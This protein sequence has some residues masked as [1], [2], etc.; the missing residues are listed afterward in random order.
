MLGY[1]GIPDHGNY[2]GPAEG[3]QFNG[4]VLDNHQSLENPLT[5]PEQGN[6]GGDRGHTVHELTIDP[7]LLDS[8]PMA[9]LNNLL[10]TIQSQSGL[11]APAVAGP[12]N[13]NLPIFSST[14]H[15]DNTPGSQYSHYSPPHLGQPLP[16]AN[17][18][19]YYP[20]AALPQ[21]PYNP[22]FM[23]NY[24]QGEGPLPSLPYPLV[25][26]PWNN[27]G[28]YSSRPRR[29]SRSSTLI[30]VE[31]NVYHSNAPPSQIGTMDNMSEEPQLQASDSY[32]PVHD[33]QSFVSHSLPT[34]GT[35]ASD[36]QI[37]YM[38]GEPYP[39]NASAGSSMPQR[40]RRTPSS[41]SSS[42]HED[43]NP[44]PTKKRGPKR[45]RGTHEPDFI[46]VRKKDRESCK[47]IC[48]T[49]FQCQYD[50]SLDNRQAISG[51]ALF[52]RADAIVKEKGKKLVGSNG[53]K[54]PKEEKEKFACRWTGCS[55]R[56]AEDAFARHFVH[57]HSPIKTLCLRCGQDLARVDLEKRHRETCCANNV[58]KRPKM[59]V[60]AWSKFE[61]VG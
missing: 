4:F 14:A 3:Q 18:A 54:V 23:Y 29:L 1:S 17:L 57:H 34:T 46:D 36:N 38:P 32:I 10:E 6:N 40:S 60:L 52:H 61:I 42:S 53:G 25:P 5:V 47:W 39:T 41:S 8:F 16:V 13:T 7:Q 11:P 27:H 51:H 35:L 20:A 15:G 31:G 22:Y 59:K 43:S 37:A 28:E 12:S 9:N 45:P 30:S 19:M 50:F 55:S 48:S 21:P 44:Y 49:G 33:A 2:M 58:L 26:G 56:L 24:S